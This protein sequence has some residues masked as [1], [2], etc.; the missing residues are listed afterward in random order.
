MPKR[1]KFLQPWRENLWKSTPCRVLD[2]YNMEKIIHARKHLAKKTMRDEREKF[3]NFSV[4]KP[5][6]SRVQF[7]T[8]KFISQ[9]DSR[10]A[11]LSKAAQDQSEDKPLPVALML[12]QG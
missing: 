4:Y 9:R 11:A 8:M 10:R 12:T 1:A 5:S 3:R 7:Y 6:K 2:N